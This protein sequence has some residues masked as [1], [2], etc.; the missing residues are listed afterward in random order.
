E[1]QRE[2][3]RDRPGAADGEVVDR[4]VHGELA[5]VAAR[6]E[7]RRHDV[8]VGRERDAA[9]VDGERRLVVERVERGVPE[10][11]QEEAL[12]ELRRK[13]SAAAVAEQDLVAR[14]DRQRARGERAGLARH[15]PAATAAS[16]VRRRPYWW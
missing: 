16:P 8:R 1:D 14:A 10:G 11:R 2:G 3:Q 6:E 9:R 12:D 7:E 13:L 15:Q 4:A 5:D